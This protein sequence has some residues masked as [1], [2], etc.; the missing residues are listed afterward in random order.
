MVVLAHFLSPVWAAVGG[1]VFVLGVPVLAWAGRLMVRHYVEGLV[2]AAAVTLAYVLAVE[3]RSSPLSAVSA[4]LALLAALAKEVYVP[5]PFLLVNLPPGDWRQ[6]L[7]SAVPHAVGRGIYALWRTWML[8]TP[9]GG[10][11]WA[12]GPGGAG[13]LV[14]RPGWGL[15][16]VTLPV[17]PAS[18]VVEPRLAVLPWLVLAV[19]FTAGARSLAV[20]RGGRVAALPVVGVLALGLLAHLVG[21][22]AFFAEAQRMSA[23]GRFVY[24]EL[25]ADELLRDPATPPAT[26]ADLAR[27][28]E[29]ELGV[30]AGGWFADDLYLCQR[31][32][33]GRVYQYAVERRAT[34]PLRRHRLAATSHGG[35]RVG[36]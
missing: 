32:P 7:R 13:E 10:Y 26:L 21:G 11:G 3:R 17:L 25:E 4:L 8:G 14:A 27:W 33:A 36:R 16:L 24:A 18:E 15:V 5:L 9:V 1:A 34:A 29:R 22:R 35:V 19:G 30:P 2:L 12:T 6:R 31:R 20:W 23:E 28:R